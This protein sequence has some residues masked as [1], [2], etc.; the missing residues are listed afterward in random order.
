MFDFRCAPVV[1][2][3]FSLA[4][5]I[6]FSLGLISKRR[7]VKSPHAQKIE[8]QD[9]ADRIHKIRQ[10]QL[11]HGRRVYNWL[12]DHQFP[13][14]ITLTKLEDNGGQFA[15]FINNGEHHLLQLSFD[16]VSKFGKECEGH[17]HYGAYGADAYFVVN[18]H[19]DFNWGLDDLVI[20]H[21]RRR[22]ESLQRLAKV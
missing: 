4:Y 13:S 20:V 17:V 5:V 2:A 22:I 6:Y 15:I 18:K 3:A 11:N 1:L 9:E 8:Q 12:G 7:A 19:T 16:F 14:W 21:V 10:H